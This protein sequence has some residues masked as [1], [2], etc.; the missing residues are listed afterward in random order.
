VFRVFG[1]FGQPLG[2]P[3]RPLTAKQLVNNNYIMNAKAAA[4]SRYS[5]QSAAHYHAAAASVP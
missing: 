3:E 4:A 2:L 5:P 1:F